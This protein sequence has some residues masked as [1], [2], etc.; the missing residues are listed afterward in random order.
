MMP[1]SLWRLRTFA[2]ANLVTLLVYGPIGGMTLILT[3]HLMLTLGWSALAAGAV[4]VPITVMLALFSGRVGALVP[5]LGARPLL[6]AGP[7]LMALG[8]V[9][10]AGIDAG[11]RYVPAVLPGTLLFAAGLVL[12]VAPVT[13]TALGA[14]PAERAGTASGVNNTTARVAQLVAVAALPL[15]AG[16]TSAALDG[17]PDSAFASGY[18]RAMLLSAAVCMVGGLAALLLPRGTGRTNTTVG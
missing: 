4:G 2:V 18:P 6:V 1:P 5:R 11:D 7:A 13:S 15:A 10:L 9:L 3:L 14:V 17:G 8:Q 16:I 12:V